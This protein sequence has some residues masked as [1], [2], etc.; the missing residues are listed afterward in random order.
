M[1]LTSKTIE[2]FILRTGKRG[3]KTLTVLGALY[4]YIHSLLETEVGQTLLEDDILRHD[5]LLTKIYRE[6]VTPQELAEFRFL[7]D[8]RLPRVIGKI[9]EYLELFKQVK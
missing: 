1:E 2:Q 5:A 7:R 4:P 8:Y 6:E 3:E 9:K